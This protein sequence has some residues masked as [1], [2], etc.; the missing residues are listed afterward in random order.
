MGFKSILSG[1]FCFYKIND[2]VVFRFPE[3]REEKIDAGQNYMCNRYDM[4]DSL[5]IIH[6]KNQ[7]FYLFLNC[8]N[9]SSLLLYLILLLQSYHLSLSNK[10]LFKF[11]LLFNFFNI[12]C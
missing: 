12:I 7:I 1:C 4:Y 9:F 8:C 3:W 10:I 6:Q 11:F 2:F 5:F